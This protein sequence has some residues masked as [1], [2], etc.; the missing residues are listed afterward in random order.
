ME[1]KFTGNEIKAVE[2]ANRYHLLGHAETYHGAG[3]MGASE[4]GLSNP[5][6]FA[7]AYAA[8]RKSAQTPSA[9]PFAGF[10]G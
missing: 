1:I 4:A 3:Y 2:I 10:N 6:A 8:M 9:D 7:D 5:Q